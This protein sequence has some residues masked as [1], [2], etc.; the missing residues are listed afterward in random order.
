MR[1][2]SM[3]PIAMITCHSSYLESRCL[4]RGYSLNEVMGCVVSRDGDQWTIDV[5]HPAYP[6]ASRLPGPPR[7]PE[8]VGH[9]PG[10]ELKKLLARIGITS[11]PDCSCNARAAEMDRL[12]VGWCRANVETIVGWLREQAEARGLPFLDLAGR[13]LVHRAIR[14]AERRTLTQARDQDNQG[15]P[16]EAAD[17]DSVPESPS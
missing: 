1:S 4:E 13:L 5:D 12:G 10:A 6:R 16:P 3:Q 15:P 17:R 14:N 8:P 11:A 7:A 9:G 2:Q